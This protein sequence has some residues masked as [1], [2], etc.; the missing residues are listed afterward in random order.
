[1]NTEVTVNGYDVDKSADMI[2]RKRMSRHDT[3]SDQL[4]C[5]QY[6]MDGYWLAYDEGVANMQPI[7]PPSGVVISDVYVNQRE[8]D[9]IQGYMDGFALGTAKRELRERRHNKLASGSPDKF[10]LFAIEREQ[11]KQMILDGTITDIEAL[12]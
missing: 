7:I 5:G 12:I 8:L 4:E 6:Y 11:T 3:I 1:M 10:N 2:T 9:W